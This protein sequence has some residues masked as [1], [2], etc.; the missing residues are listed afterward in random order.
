MKNGSPKVITNHTKSEPRAPTGWNFMISGVA[1]GRPVFV[2]FGSGK[3]PAHNLETFE[4]LSAQIP[5]PGICL[6]VRRSAVLPERQ[7]EARRG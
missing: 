5:K 4:T 3:Q 7:G 6:S 1:G 2:V